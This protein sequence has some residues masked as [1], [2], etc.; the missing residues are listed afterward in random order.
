MSEHSSTSVRSGS[1]SHPEM[2][3]ILDDVGFEWRG[4]AN[5]YDTL[6]HL[7]II[8]R[9]ADER[10]RILLNG[11]TGCGKELLAK[12]THRFAG[13]KPTEFF[14]VNCATLHE[15]VATAELFGVKKGTYTGAVTD[16]EGWFHLA[17]EKRSTILLDEVH[18]L[19][20]SVRPQL[21]RV[22]N[23][24]IFLR[25]GDPKTLF[26]FEGNVISAASSSIDDMREKGDFPQDLFSRLAD[27]DEI[28]LPS[29]DERSEEHRRILIGSVFRSL[30]QSRPVTIEDDVADALLERSFPGNIRDLRSVIKQMISYARSETGEAEQTVI[31]KSHAASVLD[32]GRWISSSRAVSMA[33]DP[34]LVPDN[35]VVF[36]PDGKPWGQQERLI[37]LRTLQI[38]DGNKSEAARRLGIQRGTL[39]RWLERSASES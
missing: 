34:A 38:C 33:V 26:P 7:W 21:Y 8:T 10:I 15:S 22:L 1:G 28:V 29:L 19:H 27:T 24:G 4:D 12:A 5:L 13:G 30:S 11:P 16:R 9:F 2:E 17:A 14:P 18:M 37:A 3:A 31:T 36:L 20:S 6:R 25:M 23:E 39:D 35:A 32:R